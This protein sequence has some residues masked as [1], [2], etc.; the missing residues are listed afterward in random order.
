MNT[1]HIPIVV[2]CCVH[3]ITCGSHTPGVPQCV[4]THT[5]SPGCRAGSRP[6]G[7]CPVSKGTPFGG[8]LARPMPGVTGWVG[9]G[10]RGQS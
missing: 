8:A 7:P 6:I 1:A 3:C 10:H 9:A 5:H 4:H 2:V